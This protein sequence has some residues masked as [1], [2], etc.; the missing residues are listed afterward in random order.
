MTESL[1]K[2]NGQNTFEKDMAGHRKTVL[3][4]VKSIRFLGYFKSI[5]E[6]I[7][8]RNIRLV[9]IFDETK[10]EA[11][12]D[13]SLFNFKKRFPHFEWYEGPYRTDR[14]AT[15]I[16]ATRNILNYRFL[17]LDANVPQRHVR[18]LH[19]YLPLLLRKLIGK[20][21]KTK[22]IIK[23]RVVE[24]IFR[25]CEYIVPAD[26]KI[27]NFIQS[28][29]PSLV[30]VLYRNFPC[31]S[32]DMDYEKSALSLSI[33]TIL[34]TPSWETLNT[35]SMIQIIPD[36]VFVWN[37]DHVKI[38]HDRHFVPLD[39]LT[40][41]GAPHFDEWFRR[42]GPE[43]SRE[44]FLKFFSIIPASRYILYLGSSPVGDEN[45]SVVHTLRTM[46]DESSNVNCRE[47]LLLVRPYP[48]VEKCY[49]VLDHKKI[50]IL[51]AS[52]ESKR[53]L[54]GDSLFYD[55]VYHAEA[56]I[57]VDTTALID[58]I[59]IGRPG[60]V[61]FED[62]FKD[63]LNADHFARVRESGAVTTVKTADD[64]DRA[65]TKILSK[66]DDTYE[67]RIE[68]LRRYIR[69]RGLEKEVGSVVASELEKF[70]R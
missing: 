57:A 51:P 58:A 55:M 67:K 60:F 25:W 62:R 18:R 30:L 33:P 53:S 48:G 11:P 31:K 43:L 24:K 47:L 1:P 65:I 66:K 8:E 32:P 69:P 9:I 61:Y 22:T 70:L 50:V 28:F 4:F 21:P 46:L 40:I 14:W 27:T 35:K 19:G 20:F 42:A 10:S 38:A 41:V 7:L 36:R 68:Y 39:K 44:I 29:S 23:S 59:A 3:F 49:N 26:D 16:I 52:E 34:I 17:L 37:E 2:N 54:Y 45:A 5:A 63:I 15:F 12:S 13:D 56:V 6:H 64:L